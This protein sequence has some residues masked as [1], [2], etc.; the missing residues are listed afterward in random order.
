MKFEC[1]HCKQQFEISDADAVNDE[2]WLAHFTKH[3]RAY[4]EAKPKSEKD[5]WRTHIKPEDR[6]SSLRIEI[7]NMA[8]HNELLYLSE[9]ERE[10]ILKPIQDKA[11]AAMT[12]LRRRFGKEDPDSN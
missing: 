2:E 8:W 1:P 11:E 6:R 5:Y 12:R 10:A 7:K 3:E 4:W 9:S